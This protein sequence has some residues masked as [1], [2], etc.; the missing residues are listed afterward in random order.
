MYFLVGHP[1]YKSLVELCDKF[2]EL[3]K[4]IND[5]NA[6]QTSVEQFVALKMKLKWT[7]DPYDFIANKAILHFTGKTSWKMFGEDS[8]KPLS[9][10]TYVV[11]TNKCILACAE[12]IR[13]IRELETMPIKEWKIVEDSE[14]P[15][16]FILRSTDPN[17][18]RRFVIE[19]SDYVSFMNYKRTFETCVSDSDRTFKVTSMFKAPTNLSK[20]L[21]IPQPSIPNDIRRA[22]DEKCCKLP[23][24]DCNASD[25]VIHPKYSRSIRN[26]PKVGPSEVFLINS[27]INGFFGQPVFKE[28]DISDDIHKICTSQ[29]M[30]FRVLS[31]TPILDLPEL[32]RGQSARIN[33][34]RHRHKLS[35]NLTSPLSEGPHE[36]ATA[37]QTS[38]RRSDIFPGNVVVKKPFPSTSDEPD[39]SDESA[40]TKPKTAKNGLFKKLAPKAANSTDSDD[41]SD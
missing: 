36:E 32:K 22:Q 30:T 27:D 34:T 31:N 8:K 41:D 33:Q 1:D 35:V 14:K 3:N 2:G 16:D 29:P 26:P 4:E 28:S 12:K 7:H 37:T 40:A 24:S 25:D 39:E 19:S 38:P 15:N 10:G 17:D 5:A 13:D 23:S 11:F 9:K 21:F 18:T 6:L 20:K